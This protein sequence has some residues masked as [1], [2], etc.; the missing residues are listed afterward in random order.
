MFLMPNEGG[1]FASKVDKWASDG[2]VTLDPYAHVAGDTKKGVD[3]GE[4]LAVGPV[5]DLGNLGVV[6]DAAFVVAFVSEYD[7]F[8]D[9]DEEFLCRDGGASTK[10]S[11]EYAVDVVQMFSDETADLVVSGNRLIPTVLG[12][13]A[14]WQTFDASVVHKGVCFVGNLGL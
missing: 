3:V 2:R 7:D 6:G 5:A 4:V 11:M 10:E 8:G 1:A 13:V 14:R 12:F 9:S